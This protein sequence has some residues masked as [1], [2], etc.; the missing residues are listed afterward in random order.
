VL[1][2]F[3]SGD[4]LKRYHVADLTVDGSSP[5]LRSNVEFLNISCTNFYKSRG[6]SVSIVT[7]LRPE[8]PGAHPACYPMGTGDSYPEGKAAGTWS[9]PLTST[10]RRAYVWS[11]IST[12]PYL[13]MVWFLRYRDSFTFYIYSYE[14]NAVGLRAC[15]QWLTDWQ[16]EVVFLKSYVHAYVSVFVVIIW[17]LLGPFALS[18][19]SYRPLLFSSEFLYTTYTLVVVDPRSFF[20][21]LSLNFLLL[22]FCRMYLV[23]AWYLVHTVPECRQESRSSW[24]STAVETFPVN[25]PY[26]ICFRILKIMRGRTW[27]TNLRPAWFCVSAHHRR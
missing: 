18:E 3:W 15:G 21:F 8:R 2:A 22:G 1:T 12:P 13:F 27:H 19:I 26:G 25:S 4:L 5:I 11:R 23:S 17:I 24:Y 9:W 7:R 20:F 16:I 10:Y 6:S 14:H